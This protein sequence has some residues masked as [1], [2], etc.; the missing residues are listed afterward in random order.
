LNLNNNEC[1]CCIDLFYSPLKKII[2]E[3][4]PLSESYPYSYNPNRSKFYYTNITLDD[5]LDIDF[6][7]LKFSIEEMVTKFPKKDNKAVVVFDNLSTMPNEYSSL[8]QGLTGIYES[9]S[10]KVTLSITY[11]A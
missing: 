5:Y 1:F 6:E 8:L 7:K 2:K 11:R 9:L 10:E 4:L 3:E